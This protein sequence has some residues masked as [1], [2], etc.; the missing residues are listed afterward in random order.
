MFENNKWIY[1]TSLIVV[2]IVA[3]FFFSR[4][5]EYSLTDE[6]TKENKRDKSIYVM[7][8]IMIGYIVFW[9]AIRN[10]YVDT[11]AYIQNY[12]RLDA[13]Q[14]LLAP[15]KQVDG[16]FL[17]KAPLFD[18]F[19]LLLKK[20]GFDWHF[21]LGSIA[22]V[23]GA[24]V[25]YGIGR[26]TDDVALS[27]FLFIT[28]MNFLWLF[29]GARQ[30]VVVCVMF[31]AL[32]LIFEKKWI[33]YF[34]LVFIMYFVHK[35][36]IIFVPLYFIANMKNWSYGIYTC[37]LVTIVMTLAF[38]GQ[39]TAML[40]SSFEEYNVVE[41]FAKDDGANVLRFLVAMVPPVIAFI[42]RRELAAF[43]NRRVNVLTNISLI[44]AGLYA[45][46]TVTSGVYMGRI[47][48]YT[49]IYN[50]IYLPFL[51]NRVVSKDVKN[52]LLI[53]CILFYLVFYG[54]QMAEISYYSTDVFEGLN[55]L[56]EI[57]VSVA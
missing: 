53:L 14:P 18:T 41:E 31:A 3:L 8:A 35:S 33:K 43:N 25:V 45:V 46:A 7:A 42:Y 26:F 21:Y 56:K 55:Y 15:W 4:Q 29:N 49:E 27:G 20:M 17:S 38:P 39:I 12:I 5:K 10:G 44:N 36:C 23:S 13:S 30:M 52:T 9:A 28:T 51:L 11:V 54:L 40:D 22:V 48:V 47:P 57:G 34:I 19:E 16:D 24:C 37:I 50:L 32:R 2:A 6:V 1:S